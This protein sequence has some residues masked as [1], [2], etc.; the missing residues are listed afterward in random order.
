MS[1]IGYD[2]R[3]RPASTPFN[4][5]TPNKLDPEAI[6]RIGEAQPKFADMVMK[7]ADKIGGSLQRY[8]EAVARKE[9][10]DKSDEG[11]QNY[12]DWHGEYSGSVQKIKNDPSLTEDQKREKVNA[13]GE[14]LKPKMTGHEKVDR[15]IHLDYRRAIIQSAIDADRAYQEKEIAVRAVKFKAAEDKGIAVARDVVNSN[16]ESIIASSADPS[17]GA[18]KV[19]ELIDT[20]KSRVDTSKFNDDELINHED[21][22]N[23]LDLEYY[24]AVMKAFREKQ[25]AEA[26]ESLAVV[27]EAASKGS[28]DAMSVLRSIDG[29]VSDAVARGAVSANRARGIKNA[30]VIT[31]STNKLT[32]LKEEVAAFSTESQ[33][34]AYTL[35]ANGDTAAYNMQMF[36]LNNEIDGRYNELEL[37]ILADKDMLI[38]D[39]MQ[40]DL[41]PEVKEANI[42]IVS[43]NFD[44]IVRDLKK[45]KAS[46]I[47]T[48]KAQRKSKEKEVSYSASKVLKQCL[49]GKDVALGGIALDTYRLMNPSKAYVDEFNSK[50][51]FKPEI[52]NHYIA[53]KGYGAYGAGKDVRMV[54]D[55]FKMTLMSLE[56][57]K[58]GDDN[59][60]QLQ[61]I[62]GD[63]AS[64]FGIESPQYSEIAASA[65]NR[66]TK[67][68]NNK[69]EELK[70][71]LDYD[72]YKGESPSKWMQ[73]VPRDLAI[74]VAKGKNYLS[75]VS[76]EEFD[77][78]Y[79]TFLETYEACRLSPDAT[80]PNEIDSATLNN[81]KVAASVE[82]PAL[83]KKEFTEGERESKKLMRSYEEGEE[84]LLKRYRLA[85]LKKERKD[86][87]WEREALVKDYWLGLAKK[88]KI[89]VDPESD[90][91]TIRSF[92]D[93]ALTIEEKFKKAKKQEE[94]EDAKYRPALEEELGKYGLSLNR[95]DYT[96]FL[97]IGGLSIGNGDEV[98]LGINPDSHSKLTIAEMREILNQYK[99]YKNA[100]SREELDNEEIKRLE[101]EL[102]GK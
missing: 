81:A 1:V 29:H 27:A 31:A 79:K 54:V 94:L 102:K 86:L 21:R 55:D 91:Q 47:E 83:P 17:E 18:R 46:E 68:K 44:S 48:I 69:G 42:K 96:S 66:F 16:F 89:P 71:M 43:E 35:F 90:I 37:G 64:M 87:Y 93:I 5:G 60:L 74:F 10:E 15:R 95:R 53:E 9:Y 32:R 63:A 8:G 3:I 11:Q 61:S 7:A 75:S 20:E 34:A 36:T 41:S 97:G 30:T 80:I 50:G 51:M 40:D 14:S 13:L 65:R 38:R 62:L 70:A 52:L 73:S 76:N 67:S 99:K 88:H 58:E 57:N 78:A 92:V 39:I 45:S 22:W 12:L 101:E 25:N 84:T 59:V 49:E 82:K 85:V 19:K 24:G 56:Y 23:A 28:G 77:S 98:E 6:G 4:A 72:I 100:K 26:D 33:K 2:G